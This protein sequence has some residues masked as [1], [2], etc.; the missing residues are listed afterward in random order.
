MSP[1]TSSVDWDLPDP[2]IMPITVNQDDI[3]VFGHVNQAVYPRWF[4][5]VAWAHSRSEGLDES[6]V[7]AVK[8]GMAVIRAE[9]DY[10][11][12]GRVGDALEIAVWISFT[13]ERLRA[14]RRFQ[15]RR[16]ADGVTLARARWDLVCF[17]LETGR[18]A[19]MTPGFIAHYY[20]RDHISAAA[21]AKFGP[22]DKDAR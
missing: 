6:G 13:D 20:N 11:A 4:S 10:L 9:I 21:K 16:P 2:F 19:R 8:R 1:Q 14:E 3:D 18:P 17:N 22:K 15:V 12:H 7:E 5:D